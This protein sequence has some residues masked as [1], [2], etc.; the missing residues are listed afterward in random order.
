MENVSDDFPLKVSETA[1]RTVLKV[2]LPDCSVYLD[3][4]TDAGSYQHDASHPQYQPHC[5][6]AKIV[7]KISSAFVT[8]MAST[9]GY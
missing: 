8:V 2:S 7:E 5:L 9:E 3:G 1:Y 6:A 4:K